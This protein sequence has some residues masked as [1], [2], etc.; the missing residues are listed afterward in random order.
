M[1]AHAWVE[2]DGTPL[3]EE[4]GIGKR[5]VSLGLELPRLVSLRT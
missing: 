5:F 3:N 2:V 4:A 1:S